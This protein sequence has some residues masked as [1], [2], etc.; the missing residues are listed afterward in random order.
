M[1][2]SDLLK[3]EHV[4]LDIP[5]RTR[6]EVL[7]YVA[8]R[9]EQAGALRSSQDLV[10]LLLDR[11]RLGATVVGAQTAIPHCKVPGLGGVVAAFA[12][13]PE[14][15]PFDLDEGLARLFFFIFSPAEQPSAHLQVLSNIARM[16]NDPQV[17]R[18]FEGATDATVLTAALSS[19]ESTP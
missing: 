14:P 2:L 5:V 1:L 16:L 6:E 4:F 11:E 17:R 15:F 8:Q 19:A 18:A 12:R 9:L 10:D 7:V 13:A 3:P